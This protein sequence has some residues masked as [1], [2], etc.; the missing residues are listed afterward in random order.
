MNKYDASMSFQFTNSGLLYSYNGKTNEVTGQTINDPIKYTPSRV[1]Q[2]LQTGDWQVVEKFPRAGIYAKL[3]GN[4][5]VFIVGPSTLGNGWVV[6]LSTGA[7]SKVRATNLTV[8]S[9]RDDRAFAISADLGVSLI[10]ALKM[11]D[12]GYG[13]L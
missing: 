12:K 4:T 13:K 6:E 10:T 2:C 7:I 8:I 9:D 11:I 3:D 1:N 5:K